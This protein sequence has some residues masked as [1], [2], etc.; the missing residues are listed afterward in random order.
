MSSKQIVLQPAYVLHQWAYRDSSAIVELFTPE[1]GRIGVV[2]RGV[3]RP[4][5]PWRGLLQPFQPLLVSWRGRGELKTLADVE[6]QGM[7]LQ[8][9]SQPLVSGFY[10]NELLMRLV[11]RLDAQ[12]TLFG[13]YD[14]SLRALAV[15]QDDAALERVLRYFERDLLAALG[16]ALVLDCEVKTGRPLT[17]AQVYDYQIERGPVGLAETEAGQGIAVHGSTLLAIRQADLSDSQARREAKR[18]MRAVLARYLGPKPLF[19]RQLLVRRS[20][21][22]EKAERHQ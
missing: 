17:Q 15:V 7:A 19:S 22:T 16:Y 11:A 12:L 13:C 2:A 1:H 9:S 18:L 3:K 14:A 8:L 20:N 5:S 6:A 4:K 21:N 10:L